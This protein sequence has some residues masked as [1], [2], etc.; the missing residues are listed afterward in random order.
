MGTRPHFGTGPAPASLDRAGRVRL[1]GEF[2]DAALSGRE[3]SRASVLF[4]A[5]A[6]SAW[7]ARGGD[8]SRDYLRVAQRGSHRTPSRIWADL[9]GDERQEAEDGDTLAP[10]SPESEREK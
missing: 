3:P 6:I 1:L 10:S 8:L 4:I 9:I 5:G 2:A 7:L